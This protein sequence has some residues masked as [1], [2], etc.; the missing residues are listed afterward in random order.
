MN[1][2]YGPELFCP[3]FLELSAGYKHSFHH[4]SLRM[5]RFSA[6]A[7]VVLGREEAA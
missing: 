1:V 4:V 5:C 7:M 2:F 3:L 6:L